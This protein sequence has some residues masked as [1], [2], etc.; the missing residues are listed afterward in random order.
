MSQFDDSFEG[1]DGFSFPA[2][3]EEEGPVVYDLPFIRRS[4]KTGKL[5][6]MRPPIPKG[7]SLVPMKY[8]RRYTDV[9][10]P[11][12]PWWRFWQRM[13]KTSPYKTP[14]E[15]Q[16]EKYW[17]RPVVRGKKRSLLDWLCN[18]D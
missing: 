14:L 10:R 4:G 5:P 8:A 9:P 3:L 12:K 18:R 13:P 2:P 15:L 6:E 1:V 11:K 7:H 16:R 17:S